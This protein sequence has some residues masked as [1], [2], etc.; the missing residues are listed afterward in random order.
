M[1]IIYDGDDQIENTF[2]HGIKKL[3]FAMNLHF[4][5]ALSDFEHYSVILLLFS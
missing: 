4:W 2:L 5:V 1:I 3:A